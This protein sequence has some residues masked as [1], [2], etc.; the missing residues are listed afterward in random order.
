MKSSTGYMTSAVLVGLLGRE[1][2]CC[3]NLINALSLA[4]ETGI[5]VPSAYSGKYNMT[6]TS[7]IITKKKNLTIYLNSFFR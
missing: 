3:P 1:S 2:E 6:K 7:G 5:T 4:K